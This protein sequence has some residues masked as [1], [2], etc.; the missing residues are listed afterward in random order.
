MIYEIYKNEL[1]A[2]FDNLLHSIDSATQKALKYQLTKKES[3]PDKRVDGIGV[4]LQGKLLYFKELMINT[5][6]EELKNDKIAGRRS[7]YGAY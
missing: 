6:R 2:A 5:I 1:E 3:E 7:E 4:E